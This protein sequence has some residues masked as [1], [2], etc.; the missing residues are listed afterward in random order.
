MRP[1]EGTAGKPGLISIAFANLD[2]SQGVIGDK[3]PRELH[4]MCAAIEAENGPGGTDTLAEEMQSIDIGTGR[5]RRHN[6]R[7]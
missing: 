3:A 1:I 4:K 5:A 7:Y 6:G 2:M